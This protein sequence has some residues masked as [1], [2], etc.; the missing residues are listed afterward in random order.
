MRARGLEGLF[1]AGGIQ[2]L[3]STSPLLTLRGLHCGHL[4]DIFMP[5]VKKLNPR[6]GH[7]AQGLGAWAARVKPSV[8][9]SASRSEVWR[10]SHSQFNQTE[11]KPEKRAS[12]FAWH[13]P[14]RRGS[15][16]ECPSRPRSWLSRLSFRY[17]HI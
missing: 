13:L 4:L 2:Y 6:G 17:Y 16:T 5:V 10:W 14:W 8:Q 11:A 7:T 1:T 12:I 3:P 15:E 9:F